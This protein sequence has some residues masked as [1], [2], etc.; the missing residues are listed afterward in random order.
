MKWVLVI[1]ATFLVLT[2]KSKK[3]H[4]AIPL[5]K[6][7]CSGQYRGIRFCHKIF[8]V[9]SKQKTAEQNNIKKSVPKINGQSWLFMGGL[10]GTC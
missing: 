10:P 9:K 6:N 2:V 5:W 4:R 3:E 7:E 1:P 8:V